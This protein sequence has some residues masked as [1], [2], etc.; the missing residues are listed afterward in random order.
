MTSL[1]TMQPS[2]A[3]NYIL[4]NFE[5]EIF[6]EYRKIEAL[7]M[8]LCTDAKH[9]QEINTL[10]VVAKMRVPS[11][12]LEIGKVDSFYEQNSIKKMIED[13]G[14]KRDLAVQAIYTWSN[15]IYDTKV[16][17]K[18]TSSLE[19]LKKHAAKGNQEKQF[20]LGKAYLKGFIVG[21]H[22]TEIVEKDPSKAFEYF[23]IS[24]KSNHA[25]AKNYVGFCYD[26]GIGITKNHKE[27]K[28]FYEQSAKQGNLNAL[29]NLANC[30]EYGI[31]IVQNESKA[32]E[33]YKKLYEQDYVEAI[34]KMAWFYENGISVSIN[35]RRALT[36]YKEA[37]E[38]GSSEAQYY[39]AQSYQDPT[40]GKP[41]ID[42]A[43]KWYY[44]AA[45]NNHPKA[46]FH[47]SQL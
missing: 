8:D 9:I 23:M 15:A 30:Y 36:L 43:K 44:L 1:E 39:L 37:A 46:D 2:E 16:S 31:G 40:N 47:L 32:L 38:K 35:K 45:K 5:N 12:M 26:Q 10:L 33:N 28:N 20:E 13:Y 14:V 27:A 6:N 3:I 17:K 25:E 24:A 4:L 18:K 19:E 7:F 22:T 34:Y 11:K 41:N 21:E 42:E 29:Y